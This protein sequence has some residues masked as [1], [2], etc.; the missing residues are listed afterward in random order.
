M[1]TRKNVIFTV[2][3]LLA[4]FLAA[5]GGTSSTPLPKKEVRVERLGWVLE[6]RSPSESDLGTSA[7]L[8]TSIK[9]A[10]TG[11]EA[12]DFASVRITDP[13]DRGIYWLFDDAADFEEKFNGENDVFFANLVVSGQDNG[14]VMALGTYTYEVVLKNGNSARE[15]LLVPAPGSADTDGYSFVYTEDYAADPPSNFVALPERAAI[16]TVTLDL[17]GARLDVAFSAVGKDIYNGWV[18]AYDAQG[19]FVG[20]SSYFRDEAGALVPELNGGAA[21]L[22]DGALNTLSVPEARMDFVDTASLADVASVVVVLTDGEQYASET[23]TN[24]DAMSVS[25]R[26][27]VVVK[28]E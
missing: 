10:D 22:K 16:Q 24:H 21:L 19:E 15:T 25:S 12:G 23:H 11:L 26:A 1:L 4:L 17:Q 5:C 7:R 13:T 14:A 3:F 28:A 8:R 18:W 6:N 2:P 9:F 20:Y 27:D